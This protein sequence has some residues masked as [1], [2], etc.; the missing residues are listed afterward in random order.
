MKRQFIFFK[1]PGTTS[2]VRVLLVLATLFVV[3][4]CYRTYWLIAMPGEGVRPAETHEFFNDDRFLTG[5]DRENYIDTGNYHPKDTL[6]LILIF[7]SIPFLF[8][9]TV[10]LIGRIMALFFNDDTLSF[11]LWTIAG[12]LFCTL[13]AI[14]LNS[15]MQCALHIKNPYKSDISVTYKKK[16]FVI[17]PGKNTSISIY[18]GIHN[19]RMKNIT[20]KDLLLNSNFVIPWQFGEFSYYI[21][22]SLF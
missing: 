2:I 10:I 18:R 9:G 15:A 19:V 17:P 11:R 3:F 16:V 22:P 6:D 4:I 1:K 8:A 21:D 14:N 5:W 7:L 13:I 20:N 12:C